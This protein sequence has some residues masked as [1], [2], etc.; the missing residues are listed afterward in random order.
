MPQV[1]I[2][3][4]SDTHGTF[5][6]LRDLDTVD[7]IVHSGDL[8]PNKTRG[9]RNIEPTFQHKWVLDR[10]HTFADWTQGKAVLYCAGN[11]DFY[12]PCGEL[13][14]WTNITGDMCITHGLTFY[15]FPYV[16]YFTGEWNY[17]LHHFERASKFN[18][19]KAVDV[20]VSHCPPYGALDTNRN[21][22]HIGDSIL[23]NAISYD[24]RLKNCQAI[25]CGHAHECGGGLETVG[26]IL[27]SNA[28]TSQRII[29]IE[30]T[31]HD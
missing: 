27:I 3:H 31:D 14:G 18:P 21:V 23:H 24:D 13:Q 29:T 16:P 11:H 28:A 4:I 7:L 8:L 17:E 30:G 5:P 12:D 15:G 10:L 1:R 22:Q 6:I 19:P 26:G 9:D 2:L 25:L 20:I